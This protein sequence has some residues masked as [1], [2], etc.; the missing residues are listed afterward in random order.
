MHG[1]LGLRG[2]PLVYAV[3]VVTANSY[4]LFGYDNGL[5]SGI[6]TSPQ[7]F[8]VF[9]P[10][11]ATMQGTVVALLEV[12]AF[13]GAI[14]CLFTGNRL[15]RRVNSFIGSSIMII[16]AVLHATSVSAKPIAIQGLY[17]FSHTVNSCP[18]DR[19]ED[20]QRMGLGYAHIN[21]PAL[22]QRMQY[23]QGTRPRY[24]HHAF[25][26]Y[27]WHQCRLLDRLW[28]LFH[29]WSCVFQDTHGH[30]DCFLPHHMCHC[31]LHPRL[32]PL[33]LSQGSGG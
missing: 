10:M 21:S 12:G 2:R 31:L 20:C 30:A 28:L 33:A 6:I 15:G 16:G 4:L 32:A 5:L 26:S 17:P 8:D 11:S 24:W 19:G 29:R 9:Q 18:I 7:F 27:H 25:F 1:Y 14:T 22:H 3:N 23:T 13:F